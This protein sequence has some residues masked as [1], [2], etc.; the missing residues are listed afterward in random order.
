[1]L[2]SNILTKYEYKDGKPV[3]MREAKPFFIDD[4]AGKAIG[5]NLFIGKRPYAAFGNS[6]GDREM[7]EWTGAG[8]GARLKMPVL[9]DDA[10]RE[11]AHGPAAGLPETKVGTFSQSLMDEATKRGWTVISIKKDW[12]R[13]H[14]ARACAEV[15]LRIG[16]RVAQ[17]AEYTASSLFV[18]LGLGDF[19]TYHRG[20]GKRKDTLPPR[21]RSLRSVG[22]GRRTLR[23]DEP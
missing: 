15:Y 1:M 12:K 10:N 22:M 14:P 2:G 4:R 19:S 9:H 3:L 5:I 6:G 11:Y 20:T 21:Q 17:N 16:D 7:L 18:A 13:V 8:E 23:S